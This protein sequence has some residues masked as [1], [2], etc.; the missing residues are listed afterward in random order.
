[1]NSSFI[2]YKE[3]HLYCSKL[4][5]KNPN[6]YVTYKRVVLSKKSSLSNLNTLHASIE[7]INKSMDNES[8]IRNNK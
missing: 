8:S 6:I 2:Q 4:L 3:K 1:M 5:N 7:T